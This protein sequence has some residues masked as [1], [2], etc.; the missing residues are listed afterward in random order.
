MLEVKVLLYERKNTC[1]G[2]FAQTFVKS[3]CP[4]V[5]H[6]PGPLISLCIFIHGWAV[7]PKCSRRFWMYIMSQH[8]DGA[9]CDIVSLAGTSMK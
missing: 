6:A 1:L 7:T 4:G 2:V 9:H 8:L 5:M 3:R